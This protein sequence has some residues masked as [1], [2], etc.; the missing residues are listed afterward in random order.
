MHHIMA[1]F[2]WILAARGVLGILLGLLAFTG[3]VALECQAEAPL[4][5]STFGRMATVVAILIVL[6]GFYAFFDGLF[7]IVLGAQD[8]GDGRRWWLLILEGILTMGLG[9]SA[10]LTPQSSI[11]VLLYWIAAWAVATGVLEILEGMEM[12]EYRER[13]GPIFLAGICSMVFGSLVL[14]ERIAGTT[15]ILLIGAYA[16]SFGVLLLVLALRLR[17]FAQNR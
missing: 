4:G 6:L 12:N 8:Y 10:W 1:K 11:L 9:L 15:L 16:L 7:S 3:L 13:R 14:T 5:L 17:R 2:W